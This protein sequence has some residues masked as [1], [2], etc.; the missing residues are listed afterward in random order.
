M[1]TRVLV[2]HCT[3]RRWLHMLL[4]VTHVLLLHGHTLRLE[5]LLHLRL[6]VIR[7]PELVNVVWI[8][9]VVQN[10]IHLFLT[11]AFLLNEV[12]TS[13]HVTTHALQSL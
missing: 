1:S 6:L 2:V 13:I 7:W 10:N 5:I 3:S 12:L 8:V 9:H 11:D 4:A